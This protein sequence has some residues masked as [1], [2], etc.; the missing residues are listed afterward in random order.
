MRYDYD[1]FSLIPDEVQS[2][3]QG[4]LNEL[5]MAPMA[6]EQK[7]LWRD[8]DVAAALQGADPVVK[9][10]FTESGF[11][12][13]QYFSGAPEG[14]FFARDAVAREEIETKLLDRLTEKLAD[15]SL[16]GANW[17]GFELN[18]FLE[19]LET[20]EPIDEIEVHELQAE[21]HKAAYARNQKKM[22]AMAVMA[23]GV[24]V[25]GFVAI[26]MMFSPV[27]VAAL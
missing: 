17:N 27:T 10:L 23:L 6:S 16:D 3:F 12:V 26:S 11:G 20:A 7:G 2:Q 4:M 1:M 18:A 13:I 19:Y 14:R 9:D 8:A 21:A 5:G 15:G 22:M 24:I 25:L